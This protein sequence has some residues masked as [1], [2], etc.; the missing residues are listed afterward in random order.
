[1]LVNGGLRIALAV[2][3]AVEQDWGDGGWGCSDDRLDVE[4]MVSCRSLL[5]W[6]RPIHTYTGLD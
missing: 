3:S 2:L 5:A 4:M 1:M 6:N